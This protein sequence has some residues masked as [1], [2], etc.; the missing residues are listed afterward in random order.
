[1]LE[2]G[3]DKIR[4]KSVK[5]TDLLIQLFK[6]KL[7]VLGY[8]LGSPSKSAQRGSHVSLKHPE[9]YRICK[10]LIDPEIGGKTV[11]PDFREPDNIRLGITPLYTTYKDIWDTVEQLKVI[12]NQKLYEKFDK[13]KDAVT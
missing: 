2:A 8:S 6:E 3:M 5:Q 1:M 9:A 11:I 4:E 12:V 7:Q 10:A 13:A